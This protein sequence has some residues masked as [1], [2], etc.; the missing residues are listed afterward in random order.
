MI[1]IFSTLVIQGLTLP[2]LLKIL[3][4]KPLLGYPEE[5]RNLRLLVANKVLSFIEHDFPD[6]INTPLKTQVKN[7]YVQI[8]EELSDG[9]VKNDPELPGKN[10]TS[11]VTYLSEQAKINA[12]QRQLLT[13]FHKEGTFNEYTLRRLEDELDQQDLELNRLSKKDKKKPE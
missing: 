2:L 7:R 4:I 1:V 12:F 8:I 5:E 11:E 3:G 6:D 10:R 13:H 9:T